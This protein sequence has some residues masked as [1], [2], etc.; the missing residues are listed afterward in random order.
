MAAPLVAAQPGSA[1]RL[2]GAG[3][4]ATLQ[5]F[6]LGDS[7]TVEAWV[8]LSTD[9]NEAIFGKH[10]G[11]STNV[12]IVGRFSNTYRVI[13][14]GTTLSFG[15]LPTDGPHHVAV[16]VRQD[17][18]AGTSEVLAYLDGHL[19]GTA[20]ANNT[21]DNGTGDWGSREWLI[22]QEWDASASDF[23]LGSVDEA[24]FWTTE[25]SVGDIRDHMHESIPS[26][27]PDF[28]D[29][30]A[31]YRFDGT[32]AAVEDET[33]NG[34]DGTFVGDAERAPSPHPIGADVTQNDAALGFGTA[35]FASVGLTL[36]YRDFVDNGAGGGV[37]FLQADRFNE[38]PVQ[39]PLGLGAAVDRYWTFHAFGAP[40]F[41]GTLTVDL[42]GAAGPLPPARDITLL[43]RSQGGAWRVLGV[44]D[45]VDGVDVT[46]AGLTEEDLDDAVLHVATRTAE[47]LSSS[48]DA[49][50]ENWRT[51]P[52]A[53]RNPYPEYLASGGN[54]GGYLTATDLASGDVW[55]FCAPAKYLGDQSALYG[56]VLRYDV[57]Q[58]NASSQFA[59]HDVRLE[60]RDGTRLVFDI[61]PNPATTWS[62]RSVTLL[63]SSG[64]TV[65]DLSGAAATE[66][67]MQDVLADL[68]AV[69]IRGEY[70]S[71][72]DRGDLDNVFMLPPSVVLE[73]TDGWRTL[74]PPFP[75]LPLGGRTAG[76]LEPIFTA[77]YRGS[78]LFVEQY[79][80]VFFYDEATGDFFTPPDPGATAPIP[81]GSGIWVYVF[82]DDERDAGVQGSFPKVLSI[83][84][85]P[86]TTSHDFGVTY[87][88]GGASGDY[89]PGINL[90]GNPYEVD[91]DWDHPDWV[92][93]GVS[94]TLYI[95]DPALGVA[96]DYR[97]WTPG[98]GGTLA[99]GAIPVGQGFHALAVAGSPV[100]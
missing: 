52:D 98:L 86:L 27:D 73:G 43:A 46:F 10:D 76:F 38:P 29:L 37:T 35:E 9:G 25:R 81:T 88:P 39:P 6:P 24:R 40:T 14:R 69:C 58:N 30:A 66:Q 84:G 34:R 71:G 64:W 59:S 93:T 70:R 23:L 13:I 75:D 1:L 99:S 85:V 22:G 90:L 2:D 18:V 97:E 4:Y 100:L 82:E 55:Y 60:G 57:R 56:G 68:A 19:V 49:D 51:T 42:G 79:A 47:Q 5:N 54:P 80:N 36:E 15:A 96:G 7:F 53:R 17:L 28:A 16:T 63:A 20:N 91:L 44:A 8:D 74:S 92:R 45:N 65:T 21:V 3:D 83:F 31:Y 62:P 72:S 32:G 26:T 67:Q 87:T 94:N 77:G 48:F 41:T 89:F 11:T 12:F 61:E 78:D 95:W 50:D 33:A